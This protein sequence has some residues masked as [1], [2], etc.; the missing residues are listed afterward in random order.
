LFRQI[1]RT[2]ARFADTQ[3][4]YSSSCAVVNERVSMFIHGLTLRNQPSYSM[5]SVRPNQTVRLAPV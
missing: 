2:D 3:V 5:P 1:T 4:F